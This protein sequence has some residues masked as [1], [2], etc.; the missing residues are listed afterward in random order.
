MA[1]IR[2]IS[3]SNLETGRYGSKSGASQIIRESLQHWEHRWMT[4]VQRK[5]PVSVNS[6][7]IKLHTVE[8]GFHTINDW[9]CAF[10]CKSVKLLS[11]LVGILCNLFTPWL[12]QRL[13]YRPTLGR[14]VDRNATDMSVY[15]ST[16]T[17]STCWPRDVGRHIDPYIISGEYQ[18][19]ASILVDTRS[20]WWPFIFGGISVDCRWYIDILSYNFMCSRVLLKA[21]NVLKTCS[22]GDWKCY[23][24]YD[25]TTSTSIF[26]IIPFHHVTENM[27]ILFGAEGRWP[28]PI[29]DIDG[30]IYCLADP[31]QFSSKLKIWSFQVIAK[32][33]RKSVMHVQSCCFA[34]QTYY[35]FVVL[36]AV[37]VI[38]S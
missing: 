35:F 37:A 5:L 34:H 28:H 21:C 25:L 2:E 22:M 30:R 23:G 26:A 12:T 15:I 32:I 9:E 3:D 16:N 7:S 14:Y 18:Y 33:V 36:V 38:V 10:L 11:L 19:L 20:I 17:Q 4:R 13:I 29:S 31:F 24:P 1:I 27:G 6:S 8:P